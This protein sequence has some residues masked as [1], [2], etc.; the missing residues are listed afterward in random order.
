MHFLTLLELSKGCLSHGMTAFIWESETMHVRARILAFELIIC[1][2][3]I[4]SDNVSFT[5]LSI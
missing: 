3:T 2:F 1:S 5:K 4:S